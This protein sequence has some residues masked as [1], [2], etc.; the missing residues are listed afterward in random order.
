MR[1]YRNHNHVSLNA[2][3]GDLGGSVCV[4]NSDNHSNQ[5]FSGIVV[6]SS[7]TAHFKTNFPAFYYL[8]YLVAVF[9]RN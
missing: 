4:G 7:F 5:A 6:S 9:E 1:V 8:K 3:I 2:S